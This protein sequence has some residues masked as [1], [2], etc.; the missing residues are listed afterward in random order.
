[1]SVAPDTTAGDTPA[2]LTTEIKVP[3]EGFRAPKGSPR[4]TS[5]DATVVLPEGMVLNPGR[6]AGLVLCPLDQDGVDQEGP[7]PV[8]GGVAGRDRGGLHPTVS[9]PLEGKVYVL[10]SQPPDVKLLVA[11]AGQGVEVKLLG[12]CT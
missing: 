1:M 8:P 12:T 6:A 9:E 4:R 10:E 5:E 3:Q 2:G 11:L 7:P